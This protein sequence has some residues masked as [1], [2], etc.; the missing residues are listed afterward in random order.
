VYTLWDKHGVDAL[1]VP[2]ILYHWSGDVVRAAVLTPVALRRKA[3]AARFWRRHRAEVLGVAVLAP[4]AYILVLS[5]LSFTPA[6]YVAPSRELSIALASAL[7]VFLLKEGD[8]RRRLTAAAVIVAG[9]VAL[10]LA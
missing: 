8:G 9:V 6:S 10:A 1:A 4:L 7:G 2:A 3:E 5:A